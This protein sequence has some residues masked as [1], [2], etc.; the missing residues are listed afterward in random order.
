M[1]QGTF[2]TRSRIKAADLRSTFAEIILR[3]PL[4]FFFNFQT[5]FF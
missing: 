1:V 3:L 4:L 5:Q 2:G